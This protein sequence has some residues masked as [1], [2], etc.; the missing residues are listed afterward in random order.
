MKT[1]P[2]L[3]FVL[4]LPAACLAIALGFAHAVQHV[5]ADE[6]PTILS[7]DVILNCV[8][9]ESTLTMPVTKKVRIDTR[10]YERQFHSK[11][12]RTCQGTTVCRISATSLLDADI[13]QSGCDDLVIVPVCAI[14]AF[15]SV[16]PYMSTEMSLPLRPGAQLVINCT[17]RANPH[18]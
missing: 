11:I 10:A 8:P 4:R 9:Q 6:A 3:S 14:G 13:A 17:G 2:P 1:V 18:F 7:E 16:T 5:R 12:A 15:E